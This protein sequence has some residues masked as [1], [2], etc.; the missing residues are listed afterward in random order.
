MLKLRWGQAM[1]AGF[2]KLN[3]YSAK[4][5]YDKQ[6]SSF[7]NYTLK[8]GMYLQKTVVFVIYQL[9]CLFVCFSGR[10]HRRKVGVPLGILPHVLEV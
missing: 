9:V 5:Y 10:L 4:I 2:H 8:V 6:L 7:L 1:S 3:E